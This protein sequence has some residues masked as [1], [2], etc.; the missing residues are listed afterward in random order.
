MR[1]QVEESTAAESARRAT[2]AAAE[3]DPLFEAHRW[4]ANLRILE[5]DEIKT[6]PDVPRSHPFAYGATKRPRLVE[7]IAEAGSVAGRG[8]STSPQDMPDALQVLVLTVAGRVNR[9]PE[10]QLAYL[11]EEQ[12]GLL[13]W[14]LGRARRVPVVGRVGS[15]RRRVCH[16]RW[17][18][19]P[20]WP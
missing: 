9:P 20:V 2:G 19:R 14:R 5:I 4:T 6:M 11:R 8:C 12:R 1:K 3:R 7:R 17:P 10:D 16:D 13:A 15:P 18:A